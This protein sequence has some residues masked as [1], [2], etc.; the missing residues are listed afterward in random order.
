MRIFNRNSTSPRQPGKEGATVG[1]G[2]I[3]RLRCLPSTSPVFNGQSWNPLLP[4]DK[5]W[6]THCHTNAAPSLCCTDPTPQRVSGQKRSVCQVRIACYRSTTMLPSEAAGQQHG[7]A[8][9]TPLSLFGKATDR[10]LVPAYSL[11][12]PPNVRSTFCEE[13]QR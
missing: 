10:G 11:A 3:C 13:G 9:G 1:K 7:V 2:K 6:A 4:A 8:D 5:K 12:P